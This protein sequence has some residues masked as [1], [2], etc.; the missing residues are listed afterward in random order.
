MKKWIR[1]GAAL[2]A[3]VLLAVTGTIGCLAAV[4]E[5]ETT[6]VVKEMDLEVTVPAGYHVLTP[7]MSENDGA[8]LLAG[9]TDPAGKLQEYRDNGI[10][11]HLLSEETG[12][13]FYYMKKESTTTQQ[14][15]N[16]RDC[17]EE[18]RQYVLEILDEADDP[19]LGIETVAELTYDHA[20]MPMVHSVAHA[21]NKKGG[22]SYEEGYSTILNGYSVTIECFMDEEGDTEKAGQLLKELML[23]TRFTNIKA[24]PTVEEARQEVLQVF[25]PLILLIGTLLMAL[26]IWTVSKK[27][28]ERRSARLTND[29]TEFNRERRL[30]RERAEKEGLTIEEPVLV[31]NETEC[32]D[33]EVETAC[34][35]HFL[36]RKPAYTF[37]LPL[38]GIV[39]L[40]V[41]VLINGDILA[42]L[43][44]AIL[45]VYL[46]LMPY[47]S[48][49]R[50]LREEKNVYRK[51]RTRGAK[52]VFCEEYMRVYGI[53]S[54]AQH[55]YFCLWKVIETKN[56]YYL[57]Y[58]YDRCYIMRKD[59]FAVGSEEEFR[60]LMREKVGKKAQLKK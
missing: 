28:K 43:L 24:P 18:N 27:R 49:R 30:M 5:K 16:L 8:F 34:K 36:K 58:T 25:L 40:A 11:L 39:Y 54:A 21:D 37:G 38:L 23:G 31:I 41:A 48:Y 51:L 6:V 10:Y 44:M 42:R 14:V 7:D 9:I 3:A 22:T 33:E 50:T 59:G 13:S 29:L 2:C 12:L 19:D 52:Y 32:T 57:Y 46:F 55:P 20:Q 53:Q 15:F 4:T 26:I 47:L 35:A 60:R 45:G 17:T 56:C 1:R